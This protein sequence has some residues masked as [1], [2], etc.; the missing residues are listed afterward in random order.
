MYINYI[1]KTGKL[2]TSC[3]TQK[4]CSPYDTTSNRAVISVTHHHMRGAG[5]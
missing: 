4:H 1:N 3:S 5:A 2:A